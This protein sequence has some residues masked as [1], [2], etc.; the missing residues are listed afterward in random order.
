MTLAYTLGRL[1]TVF[2][3]GQFVLLGVIFT[4]VVYGAMIYLAYALPALIYQS[5]KALLRVVVGLVL[6][7]SV[8]MASG[9]MPG[10]A[11]GEA[12]M[13]LIPAGFIGWS[14]KKNKSLLWSYVGGVSLAMVLTVIVFYN[15]WPEL[16][17][18]FKITFGKTI[19][20]ALIMANTEGYSPAEV[21]EM[22]VAAQ[23]FS[24]GMAR[25]I[26]ASMVMITVIPLSIGFLLVYYRAITDPE[27]KQRVLD[28]T[29][30][31]VP[32]ALTPVVIVAVLMRLLGGEGL[33]IVADNLILILAIYY[34]VG[35]LSL[36]EYG[37][38]RFQLS[39]AMRIV[40]YI[41]FLFTGVV[42]FAM[43]AIAG[44][45]DSFAD[46][47]LRADKQIELKR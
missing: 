15:I 33:Q 45:I 43:S 30:W 18:S 25:I 11:F 21:S 13:F 3:T 16:I 14:I 26:P 24:A 36:V 5:R 22:K 6:I 27:L 46:I 10:L 17:E 28:F 41:L 7:G 35:G 20:N 9:N 40:F 31:K 8:I 2:F 4:V 34:V 42:G 38:K 32:F 1:G 23:N 39:L 12:V 47:R 44:F 19:D 37:L 29:R